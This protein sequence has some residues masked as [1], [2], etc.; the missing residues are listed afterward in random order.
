MEFPAEQ[1]GVG[2]ASAGATFLLV[3]G[4]VTSTTIHYTEMGRKMG[5]K[6]GFERLAR[7]LRSTGSS[8]TKLGEPFVERMIA[9]NSR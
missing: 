6:V 1:V 5:R 4:G 3:G 7:S 9:W 2:K 8:K